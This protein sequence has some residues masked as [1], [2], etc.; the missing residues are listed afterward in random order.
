MNPI[1]SPIGRLTGLCAL[2]LA[3]TA[4]SMPGCEDGGARAQVQGLQQQNQQLLKAVQTLDSQ[5][6]AITSEMVQVKT[7]LAQVANTVLEQ[8]AKLDGMPSAGKAGSRAPQKK[9]PTGKR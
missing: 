3:T 8:K 2:F 9:K 6:R 5:V 1:T 4:L 7:L